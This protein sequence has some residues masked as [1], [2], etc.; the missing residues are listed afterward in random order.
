[1]NTKT[2]A[3]YEFSL[4][5]QLKVT[6]FPAV[7]FQVSATKYYVIARGYTDYATLKERIENV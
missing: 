6:G 2:K 3:N 7:L 5:K 4:V 1:M